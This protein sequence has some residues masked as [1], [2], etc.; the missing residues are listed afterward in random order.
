MVRKFKIFPYTFYQANVGL[1][2]EPI[3]FVDGKYLDMISK[4]RQISPPLQ[5]IG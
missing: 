2:Q 3:S 4:R 5:T 1:Y